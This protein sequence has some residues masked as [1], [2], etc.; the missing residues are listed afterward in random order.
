MEVTN[1]ITIEAPVDRVWALTVDVETWPSHTPTMTAVKKVDSA[2][3]SVGSK[4]RVKQPGQRERVWTVTALE[5][6][7]VFAWAT[8]TMGMTMTGTHLLAG[9]ATGTTQTLRVD[10][11][12]P[13][14]RLVGGLL[15]R[16]ISKAITA[17][18]QGFKAAAER[19]VS[20]S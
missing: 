20:G 14:S 16:S 11:A 17:E 19:Q 2:A 18:N 13:L 6:G 5:P 3:L 15:R 8:R 1:T 12:G 9:S 10:L 7:S 4:A